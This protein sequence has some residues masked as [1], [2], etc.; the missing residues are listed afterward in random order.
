MKVY[1]LGD[2]ISIQYGPYLEKYLSGIMD[3]ARKEG[4]EEALLNLDKPQ[5]ANGG[6]SALVLSFLQAR[7]AAGGIDADVLLL[8]CGL[9]DLRTDPVTSAKQAPLNQY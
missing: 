5:G 4:V 6:D 1:V 9:H 8:N 7:A 2:S 3:Y